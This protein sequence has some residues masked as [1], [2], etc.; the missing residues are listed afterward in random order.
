MPQKI[1]LDCDPGIDDAL[2]IVFA[3]GHPDLEILGIT[4]V[5]GNVSLDKTTAN[6]LR[7]CEFIGARDVPVVAGS[8]RPLLR[9]P[10]TAHGAHG[11]SGLDG[12]R[13]PPPGSPPRGGHAVDF[14][15]ETIGAAPGEITLI[16]TGPLTNVALAVRRQP[17]LVRQVRDFVIM[18]GSAGR[19]NVT[20]AAEFN[21]AADPEAASIVF[22]A[23]WTVTMVGLDVTLRARAGPAITQRIGALGRLADDL[24][25]P[26]LTRYTTTTPGP[27][28]PA[29]HDVC[30]VAHVASAGLL[31]C[32]PARVEVETAGR[33]TTGM[34]VTDFAGADLEYNALVAMEIDVASFWDQVLTAYTRVAAAIDTQP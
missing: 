11:E 28:G 16:A 17:D 2:A 8:P 7:V 33:F 29:V 19:G 18:G 12:A 22:G 20:P 13:L 34:T 25:L 3:W 31:S 14:L 23:G 21:I 5:A 24:L 15:A 9:P 4:T 10:L 30:A 32:V 26:C 1:I 6:A 27:D